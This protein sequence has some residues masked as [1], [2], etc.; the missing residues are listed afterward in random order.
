MGREKRAGAI[1]GEI[2]NLSWFL[3]VATCLYAYTYCS[4]ETLDQE[5]KH[6]A[7]AMVISYLNFYAILVL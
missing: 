7:K 1:A 5:S 3:R 2:R 4:F 6:N